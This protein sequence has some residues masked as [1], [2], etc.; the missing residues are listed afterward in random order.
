MGTLQIALRGSEEAR[1]LIGLLAHYLEYCGVG[2]KP[3][4]GMGMVENRLQQR[5]ANPESLPAEDRMS[6][7]Y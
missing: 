4:L 6:D 1:R 2:M 5:S 7:E 3:A